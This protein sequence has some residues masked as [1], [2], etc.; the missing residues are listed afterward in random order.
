MI[1]PRDLLERPAE[2]AAR[3]IAL[4]FLDEAAAARLRIEA[5]ADD[6]ALHDFRVAIRR[7]RSSVRAHRSMLPEMDKKRRRALRG[8]QQ[9]TN[10]ARDL[11][12]QI[13]WLDKLSR[14]GKAWPALDRDAALAVARL[15]G[16][17]G[18]RRRVAEV[19]GVGEALTR[20]T[21]VAADL[22][23]VLS[24]VSFALDEDPLPYRRVVAGL[25]REHTAEIAQQIAWVAAID[26]HEHI[27]EARISGKRLRYLVEPLRPYLPRAKAMIKEL[28][29][30]QDLL[31]DL[32]DMHVL[33]SEVFEREPS[34]PVVL[35]AR[36]ALEERVEQNSQRL[37]E[38]FLAWRDEQLPVLQRHLGELADLLE[39]RAEL[40]IERKYLLS[41]M[42]DV[43][44]L[45]GTRE[46]GLRQGYIPGTAVAERLRAQ[47]TSGGVE[48]RRTVKL[49]EGAT[50]FEFEERIDVELFDKLW[51]ATEGARVEKRRFKVPDG[52]HVWEVDEFLD[53]ALVLAEI[54]LDD[55]ETDVAF[56]AWLA[57]FV[58]REVTEES[59]YLNLTLA[60]NA[61]VPGVES[62]AAPAPEKAAPEKSAAKKAAPKKSAAKK[63]AP[64]KSAAK[65]SA[66]KEG[67]P[68]KSAP[69]KAA[70]KKAAPKKAASQSTRTEVSEAE[71]AGPAPTRKTSTRKAPTRKAPTRK[72][73]TRKAPIPKVSSPSGEEAPASRPAHARARRGSVI[74]QLPAEPEAAVSA[75]TA[76][77]ETRDE[78]TS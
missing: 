63:A 24:K 68:K 66:A 31:G 64:K 53:R 57:P 38:S 51:P 30:Y 48:Y 2:E 52:E 4:S 70:P 45:P 11:E 42:P 39:G 69:K 12:V 19:D 59:A 72:T 5:Q 75:E 3:R 34:S 7:L 15:Q 40:E 54:E 41:G 78:P 58:V 28:K 49:G 77:A 33:V 13:S 9:A 18:E 26:D 27:H 1:L 21:K 62:A 74:V 44:A 25:V 29:V 43:F 73:S 6:E 60:Q 61:G 16:V 71:S 22:R 37:Y 10:G 65:K 76:S 55:E 47:Q 36:T 17:L 8:L 46:V 23:G 67:A 20:H 35:A 14:K 50:R 56:P 32:R